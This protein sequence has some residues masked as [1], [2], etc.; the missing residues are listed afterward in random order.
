MVRWHQVKPAVGFGKAVA[1]SLVF[2]A[3]SCSGW[4]VKN[5]KGEKL[6][7]VRGSMSHA[8]VYRCLLLQLVFL[9]SHN[10][11]LHRCH[12][13]GIELKGVLPNGV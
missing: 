9:F 11:L 8:T 7:R 2:P 5:G 12:T 4:S 6:P 3:A 13:V 1:E 10:S